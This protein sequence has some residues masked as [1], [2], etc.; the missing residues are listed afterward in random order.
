M[1]PALS[2]MAAALVGLCAWRSVWTIALALIIPILVGLQ[3]TR[4]RALLTAVAYYTAVSWPVVTAYRNFASAGAWSLGLTVWL[5]ASALLALP[6]AAAWTTNR[7]AFGWRMPCALLIQAVPPL[8][9][10]GWGSPLVSAGVL[11]PGTSW[12][13][14]LAVCAVPAIAVCKPRFLTIVAGVVLG[15]HMAAS[16]ANVPTGWQAASLM[17]ATHPDLSDME[18]VQTV[19]RESKAKV[20]LLPEAVVRRWNPATELFWIDTL[21]QLADQHRTA[22]IGAAQQLPDEDRFLNTAVIING[23][24]SA[25]FVQRIPVPIGMWRPW[26]TTAGV[27]LK[28]SNPG[29]AI[30]GGERVAIL[31]CYEQ[32]LVWPYLQSAAEHPTLMAGMSNQYWVRDTPIPSAQRACLEAWARLF[33]LPLLIAENK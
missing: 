30:I 1:A 8:G 19:I 9:L 31:I 17:A 16:P 21:N 5:T 28:L 29:T 6:M 11:F 25:T 20:L 24:E 32:L 22:I 15:S 14:L 27:P 18:A 23:A 3:P 13:G 4:G 12:F 33:G 10:I 2:V 7:A 26:T